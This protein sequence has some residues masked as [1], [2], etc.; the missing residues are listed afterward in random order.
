MLIFQGVS[1]CK[2][3]YEAISVLE[4]HEGVPGCSS[5]FSSRKSFM[6]TSVAPF[7]DEKSVA[8]WVNFH[9]V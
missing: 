2:D 8:I 6:E 3:S 1:H 5:V 7:H 9:L 4:C